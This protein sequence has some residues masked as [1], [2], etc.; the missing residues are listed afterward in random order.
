MKEGNK[1]FL[2]NKGNKGKVIGGGKKMR[3]NIEG[4]IIEVNKNEK[5]DNYVYRLFQNGE[6][7]LVEV[8]TSQDT[9]KEGD[10]VRVIGRLF[11]N[12][13]RGKVYTRVY[14]D[15]MEVVY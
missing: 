11:I 5:M 12:T 2:A 14:A 9:V 15:E 4:K 3:V 8:V 6:R 13:Y 1:I 10:D 7:E